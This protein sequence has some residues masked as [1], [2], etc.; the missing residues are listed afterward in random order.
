METTNLV[1]R[2]VETLGVCERSLQELLGQAV[3]A[4]DYEAIMELTTMAKTVAEIAG[5]AKDGHPGAA[6]A[7]ADPPASAAPEQSVARKKTGDYPRFIKRGDDLIKIG[8]SKKEKKTY[9]HK[10]P[11]KAV[12]AVVIALAKVGTDGKVFATDKLLPVTN[13][14]DGAPV[15]EYQVYVALAWLKHIGLIDQHG[16]QGH[17]IP[18]AATLDRAVETVW[19]QLTER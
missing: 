7:P 12:D 14:D 8:W 11:R 2:G 6:M 13:P 17:S 3:A 16:R 19:G 10:I 4:R 18:R 5:S 1:H 15:P 9:Q